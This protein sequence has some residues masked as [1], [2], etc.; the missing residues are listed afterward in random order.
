MDDFEA[1]YLAIR[2]KRK[3]Y[4]LLAKESKFKDKTERYKDVHD[5]YS[6][7]IDVMENIRPSI[8]KGI[9][10]SGEEGF[11]QFSDDFND[12]RGKDGPDKKEK[13]SDAT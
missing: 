5:E 4:Q 3:G 6:R 13:K 12:V 2:I 11:Y 7:L 10:P 9:F 8:E 1:L